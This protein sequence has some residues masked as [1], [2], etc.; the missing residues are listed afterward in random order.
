MGPIGCPK[1]RYIITFSDY[2]TSEDGTDS[3]PE[4]SVQNYQYTL[5]KIPG[6]CTRKN[7]KREELQIDSMYLEQVQSYKYLGSTVNIWDQL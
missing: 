2:F 4:T 1:S 5:R 7:Y 3:S 6:E